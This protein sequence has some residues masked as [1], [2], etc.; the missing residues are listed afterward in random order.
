MSN[1]EV[2]DLNPR[3]NYINAIPYYKS[4]IISNEKV[5]FEIIIESIFIYNKN[6]F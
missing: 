5:E 6:L 2:I 3:L 1:L 4:S